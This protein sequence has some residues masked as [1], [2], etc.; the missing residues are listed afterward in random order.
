[1]QPEQTLGTDQYRPLR[2][3][4]HQDGGVEQ[5]EDPHAARHLQHVRNGIRVGVPVG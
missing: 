4:E 5:V 1:M 3:Q 2:Q